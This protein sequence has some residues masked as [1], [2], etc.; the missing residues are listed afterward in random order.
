LTPTGETQRDVAANVLGAIGLITIGRSDQIGMVYG[1]SRGCV[2]IPAGRGE[3]HI[4]N[5]LHRFYHHTREQHAASDI[6]CQ[7]DYVA[8][9]YRR[10]MLVVVV[11]DEPDID[12][13]L[14]DTVTRLRARHDVL[15]PMVSD[16]PAVAGTGDDRGGYDVATGA[17]VMSGAALGPRIIAAYRR[18][19]HERVRQLVDFMT[20]HAIPSA[21]ISGSA[22]IRRSLLEMTGA[23]A[24][25]G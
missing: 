19:E 14:N 25:A 7:L 12:D 1:D 3:T 24:R 10:P 16:M 15:W 17:L 13:R 23:F 5:M 11:S 21:R 6:E 18:A 4:E 22:D 8:T 9:H 2:N 20:D